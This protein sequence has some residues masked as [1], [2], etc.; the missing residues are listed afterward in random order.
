MMLV[1]VVIMAVEAALLIQLLFRGVGCCC[2]LGLPLVLSLLRRSNRGIN[3]DA[4][5]EPRRHAA[6]A[7]PDSP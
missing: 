7:A 3:D 6:V 2:D 4:W 5:Q 1:V